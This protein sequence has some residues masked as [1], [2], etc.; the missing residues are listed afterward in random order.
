MSHA[1]GEHCLQDKNPCIYLALYFSCYNDPIGEAKLS[2]TTERECCIVCV[3][4]CVCIVCIGCVYVCSAPISYQGPNQQNGAW[5]I[6]N[7]ISILIKPTTAMLHCTP[8]VRVC[9]CMV[10]CV[11][12]GRHC[13][14]LKGPYRSG[15]TNH[16]NRLSLPHSNIRNQY[17]WPK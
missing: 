1:S 7:R 17:N 11:C 2:G 14:Q 15:W 9:V 8:G 3:C 13:D 6:S 5:L 12:M 16:C 10:V 4:L